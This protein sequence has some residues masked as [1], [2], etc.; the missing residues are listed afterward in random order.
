MLGRQS[1]KTLGGGGGDH[2]GNMILDF[3][4][5]VH[6]QNSILLVFKNVNFDK[7]LCFL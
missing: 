5:T 1:Q 4:E 2:K 6:T 7:K 3:T